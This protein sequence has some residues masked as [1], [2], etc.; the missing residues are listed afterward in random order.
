MADG[1][2]FDGLEEQ[3]NLKRREFFSAANAAAAGGGRGGKAQ[4]YQL[5][6]SYDEA[7]ERLARAVETD[8][9]Y[10]ESDREG[11]LNRLRQERNMLR[12]LIGLPTDYTF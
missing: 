1:T 6:E 11:R 10:P 8:P 5:A 9:G 4:V 2:S 3:A 7:L 12:S